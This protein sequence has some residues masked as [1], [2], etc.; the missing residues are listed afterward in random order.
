M[1]VVKVHDNIETL[2]LKILKYMKH[3]SI[4]RETSRDQAFIFYKTRLQKNH[5]QKDKCAID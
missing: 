2:L 4:L 5:P 1:K 3:N